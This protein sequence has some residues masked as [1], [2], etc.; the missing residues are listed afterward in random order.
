MTAPDTWVAP[1]PLSK[2]V[3]VVTVN[4]SIGSL[5]VAVSAL[6]TAI[7]VAPLAGLVAETDGGVGSGVA[8]V[9]KVPI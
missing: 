2:S 7:P 5:K 1:G 9:V 4:G 3:A 8:P 6:L